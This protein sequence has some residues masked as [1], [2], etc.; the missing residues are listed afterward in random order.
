MAQAIINSAK[1][2]VEHMKIAGGKGTGF[3]HETAALPAPDT[4]PA[5]TRVI[6]QRPGVRVTQ[7]RMK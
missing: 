4:L 6:K 7:H 1:V 3:I 5:G 2:E